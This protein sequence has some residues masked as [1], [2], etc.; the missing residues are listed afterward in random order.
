MRAFLICDILVKDR[1]WLNEYLNLSQHTLELFGGKFHVQAGKL[2]TIEGDW[3]PKVIII[4]EFPSVEKAKEWYHSSEYAN[5]LKV[6]PKA[7]E[8]NMIIV[9]G[10]A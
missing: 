2:E 7:M 1:E 9:E 6:R 3:N 10:L 4:A 5:A 8:R